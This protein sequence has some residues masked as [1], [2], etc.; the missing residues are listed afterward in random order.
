MYR[1]IQEHAPIEDGLYADILSD[2]AY[3][4][5]IELA[6]C[7]HGVQPIYLIPLDR[8]TANAKENF[9]HE[10]MENDSYK[11]FN[12]YED[13]CRWFNTNVQTLA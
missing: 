6:I 1:L 3:E 13:Y 5:E 2:L 12:F 9:D 8:L 7:P 10:Q 11:V 4:D